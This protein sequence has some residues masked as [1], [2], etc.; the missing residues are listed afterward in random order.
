MVRSFIMFCIEQYHGIHIH[1]PA[2]N[3][4][5][6]L[7]TI[8]FIIISRLFYALQ[9]VVQLSLKLCGVKFTLLFGRDFARGNWIFQLQNFTLSVC[10]VCMRAVFVLSVREIFFFVCSGSIQVQGCYLW[11]NRVK[12][13]VIWAIEKKQKKKR[14]KQ[15]VFI[16]VVI[17]N[18]CPVF[19]KCCSTALC[20]P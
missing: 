20:L 9:S 7:F 10:S 11:Q 16:A 15:I 5:Q 17:V 19:T 8:S 1:T 2:E 14:K 4:K 3:S 6:L 13:R 18:G 12:I